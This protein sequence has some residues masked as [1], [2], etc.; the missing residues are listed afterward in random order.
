M[1]WPET[2]VRP[3]QDIKADKTFALALKHVL[4]LEGGWSNHP[5]DKGGPTNKGITLKTFERAID[6]GFV[7]S[8]TD[9]LITA[10]K[11]IT[12]ATVKKI[13]FNY[14]WQKAACQHLP[15]ALA[16]LHF[17][18]AVNHGPRRAIKFLQETIGAKIDGEFGPETKTKVRT[19]QVSNYLATYIVIRKTYYQQL[20]Q[21]PVF[22]K[23]WMN[24]LHSV[25][26]F[27]KA[28]LPRNTQDIN[29]SK[30]EPTTMVTETTITNS[31]WWG[32]SLT[33]WGTIVTA[34]STILPVIGP[35]IGLDISAEMIE[36]LGET[37][38]RLIQIIGGITGTTMTLYGRTRA[39]TRLTRRAINMKI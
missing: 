18:A 2:T 39:D 4:K 3:P 25:E 1:R 23:G 24:R 19:D 35:F 16:I 12:D 5:A 28:Q 26:N 8:N 22:G 34:L 32:E 37:V 14:Y 21:F 33:I 7:I 15:K 36:Q 38:T 31:K 13:Y 11:N 6:D 9:D 27:S 30:K 17:D 10:L 29:T 20:K